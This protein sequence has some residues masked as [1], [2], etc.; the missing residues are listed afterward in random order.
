M[1]KALAPAAWLMFWAAVA[2]ATLTLMR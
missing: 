1:G 2:Y